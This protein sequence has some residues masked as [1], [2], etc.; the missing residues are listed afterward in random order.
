M[1]IIIVSG[2][3]GSGKSTV[4]DVFEDL[5]YY[6][7][8]NLPISFLTKFIDFCESESKINYLV[9][10]VDIR[11][12]GT[13]E[14]FVEI[15]RELKKTEK[16][17]KIIFTEAHPK[18]LIRRYSE[19][20]RPH[21][22]GTTSIDDAIN[23]EILTL[24]KIKE[25]AEIVIDTT[26]TNVHELKM[27]IKKYAEASSPSDSLNVNL[28]SFGF[29]YGIPLESD[30]MLD[31][32][33][34]PNPYFD[35]NL[36]NLTGIDKSVIQFLAKLKDTRLFLKKQN[37]LLN[38]LLRQYSKEGRAKLTISIGCTGGKHRSVFIAEK[39]KKHLIKRYPLLNLKHRDIKK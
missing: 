20:R 12:M 38:F 15:I 1:K 16:S 6:C 19:S 39:I 30:V 7:V 2:L 10:S 25:L 23:K 33:F 14:E 27:L 37:A 13:I 11:S 4:M 28:I 36:K 18:I 3:S 31:V 22:F 24:S 35:E 21:P 17:L 8:E 5:G 9:L 26:R 32:R 34:L 29:K